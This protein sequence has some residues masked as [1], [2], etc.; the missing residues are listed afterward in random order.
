MI[1]SVEWWL[2]DTEGTRLARLIVGQETLQ[3]QSDDDL[4][5]KATS[6]LNRRRAT[7]LWRG[8][9]SMRTFLHEFSGSTQNQSL[10]I[11]VRFT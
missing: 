3:V 6:W 4:L 7:D 9:D 11:Q 8:C 5:R 2:T 10:P 1:Q